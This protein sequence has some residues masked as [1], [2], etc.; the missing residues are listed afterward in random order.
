MKTYQRSTALRAAAITGVLALTLAACG[1]G[2]AGGEADGEGGAT[3]RLLGTELWAAEP[4]LASSPGMNGAWFASVPDGNW[5]A[6]R[7]ADVPHFVAGRALIESGKYPFADLVSH[8]LPLER[9]AEGIAAIG[10]TY[11]IDGVEIR[12]VAVAAHGT[13]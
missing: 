6:V 2:D 13:G 1:T 10:G 3:A 4:S 9:V 11:R 12:K 7:G 8:P 5:V